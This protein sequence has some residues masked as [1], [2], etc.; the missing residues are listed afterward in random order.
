MTTASELSAD[1]TEPRS[2]ALKTLVERGYVNQA[3]NVAG[4]DDA[5]STVSC[6]PMQGSTPLLTAYMSAISCSSCPLGGCSRPAIS[7]SC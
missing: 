6:P 4:L 2:L 7:P 1:N 5:F 3:T